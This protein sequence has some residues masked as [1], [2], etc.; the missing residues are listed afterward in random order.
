MQVNL[1]GLCEIF[2]EQ[3]K[4]PVYRYI[5]DPPGSDPHPQV[6][7]EDHLTV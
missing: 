3:V 4:W 5:A 7:M 6:I 2:H 1:G